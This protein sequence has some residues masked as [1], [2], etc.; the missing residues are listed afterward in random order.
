VIADRASV[1]RALARGAL[2]WDV[3]DAQDFLRGHLPGAIS[4]GD[5]ARAL[6]DGSGAAFLPATELEPLISSAGLD[7]SRE[8]VVYG[9]RGSWQPYVARHALERVG[10]RRVSVYDGGVEDWQ[11]AGLALE[12]GPPRL[13]PARVSLR[14]PALRSIGT[15]EMLSRLNQPWA[16]L[17]DVRAPAEYRGDDAR[18]LRGGRI[19][20]A[21]N[22]PHAG[23]RLD[24]PAGDAPA[25]SLRPVDE[26]RALY[27]ALDPRK[28]TIVYDHD[29]TWAAQ[30]A[31]VL[32]ALGFRNVR[33]YDASWLGWSATLDAPVDAER[34]VDVGAL[35][36]RIS[37]LQ[38]RVAELERELS[39]AARAPR[40]GLAA[41]PR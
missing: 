29:G 14:E 33:V 25:G 24:A 1:E 34:F 38:S 19:P 5:A 13:R 10:A 9:S 36:A 20:G 6:R 7:P 12:A 18:A 32:Q 4:I 23:N 17:V 31:A 26:L 35:D 40:A 21:V 3:R 15:G 30:T 11:A 27:A 8:I 41:P 37:G 39:A 2:V 16:Q 22:V 28:E